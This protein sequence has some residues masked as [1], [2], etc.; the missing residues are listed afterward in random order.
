MSFYHIGK[1]NFLVVGLRILIKEKML[2]IPQC[3]I[4]D[5]LDTNIYNGGA[6][7]MGMGMSRHFYEGNEKENASLNRICQNWANF[8][9]FEINFGAKWW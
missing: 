5:T 2:P 8:D 7:I 4:H 3:F 1:F 9:K 6:S